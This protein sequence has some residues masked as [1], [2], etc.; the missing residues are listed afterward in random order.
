MTTS[1]IVVQHGDK[2]RHPG[3]PGL[4]ASGRSQAAATAAW[5]AESETP[6]ALYSS[7]IRRAVET[8]GT[9]AEALGLSIVST[10]GF[11]NG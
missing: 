5:L 6:S 3:D 2:E 9:I 7:P 1:V 11:G 4:T 10:H 8:A